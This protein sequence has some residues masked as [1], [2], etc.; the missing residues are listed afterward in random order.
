LN[1]IVYDDID[2]H[3]ARAGSIE[4]AATPIGV[5]LAWCVNLSL[6]S[7]DLLLDAGREALR[8]RLREITGSELLIKACHGRLTSDH[9]SIQGRDFTTRRYP[10]YLAAY[11]RTF[12]VAADGIY[13]VADSW[14]NYDRVAAILTRWHLGDPPARTNQGRRWWQRLG[15]RAK[16]R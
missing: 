11:A 3:I 6:V 16:L 12:G 8:V 14:D 15:S 13:E 2:R 9:L 7:D 10:G 1:A 4:R 5:Y